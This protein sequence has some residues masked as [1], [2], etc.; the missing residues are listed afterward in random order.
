MKYA[1]RLVLK[2]AIKDYIF[3]LKCNDIDI[4]S[5]CENFFHSEQFDLITECAEM[6]N[7]NEEYIIRTCR[8][9]VSNNAKK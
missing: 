3:S 8:K 2:R 9:M 1:A 4:I 7:L 6:R 5:E